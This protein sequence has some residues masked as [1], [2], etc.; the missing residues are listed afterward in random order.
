MYF[1]HPTLVPPFNTAIVNG[2]NALTS[3][4]VKLG[5]WPDYVA[6]R[7]EVIRLNGLGRDLLSNDLGAIAGL[8]FD[9]GTGR[10]VPPP[11]SDQAAARELWECEM[12][13]D[14]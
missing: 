3:S 13:A 12:A 8:L 6:M 9:I 1:I 4:R 14:S 5:R 2:Y 7:E 11:V 10:Y